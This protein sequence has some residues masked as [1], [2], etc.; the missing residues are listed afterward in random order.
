MDLSALLLPGAQKL[1]TAML[2]DA[3]TLTRDAIA[4]RWGRGDVDA[5][6]K[7]VAELDD[8]RSQALEL[9]GRDLGNER[10]MNAFLAGYVA[11]LARTQPE[12]VDALVSLDLE[13]GLPAGGTVGNVNTGRV[14]KLVQIDGDVRG[15]I[16]M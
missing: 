11:A 9:F 14:G 10:L 7:A 12:R 1:A 2:G 15:G 16:H 6:D 4:R 8:S 13:P 5:T 3:W